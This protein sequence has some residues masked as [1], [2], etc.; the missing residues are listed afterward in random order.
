M[1]TAELL[2]FC[3]KVPTGKSKLAAEATPRVLMNLRRVLFIFSV[4]FR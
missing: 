2:R 4:I 3:A 1:M